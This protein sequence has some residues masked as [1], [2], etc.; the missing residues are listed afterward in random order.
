MTVGVA[1]PARDGR[2]Q[3]EQHGSEDESELPAQ[4]PA[5][6]V[7]LARAD[8]RDAE[9][10]ED[11]RD[12]A[13]CERAADDV[14][15][16]VVDSEQRDDQLGRIAE[17]GIEEAAD[18]R[19]GVLGRVLGRFADHPGE[20]DESGCG[21]SELDD[22]TDIEGE[23]DDER[24][25]HEGERGPDQFPRHG[26]TLLRH[27]TPPDRTPRPPSTG[28]RPGGHVQSGCISLP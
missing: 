5:V 11:I 23:T 9:D 27:S 3:E 4:R 18:A 28:F 19:A 24:G 8:H 16:P 22:V 10:E 1:V 14:R 7:L 26:R 15:Q 17:A 2:D 12:D 21:D 20:R 25:R 6:D 13:A